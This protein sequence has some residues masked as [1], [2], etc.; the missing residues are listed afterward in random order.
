MCGSCVLRDVQTGLDAAGTTAGFHPQQLLQEGNEVTK[1]FS[2]ITSTA[3]VHCDVIF[4]KCVCDFL[5][6]YFPLSF[7][8]HAGT[9]RELHVI[10]FVL[11]CTMT[12][13]AF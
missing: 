8:V 7:I 3:N 4:L 13:K 2:V 12:K 5:I 1:V 6:I 10:N 11:N 9:G